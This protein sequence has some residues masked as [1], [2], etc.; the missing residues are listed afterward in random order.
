MTN[1]QGPM[2]KECHKLQLEPI[3]GVDGEEPMD[4]MDEMARTGPAGMIT[5]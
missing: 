2:T 5:R 4:E 1:V 3:S